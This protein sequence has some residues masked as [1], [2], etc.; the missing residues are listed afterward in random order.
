MREV[1][2]QSPRCVSMLQGGGELR[3]RS[4]WCSVSVGA[5]AAEAA[6]CLSVAFP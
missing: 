4:G 1:Q 2:G 5:A 6:L 3:W